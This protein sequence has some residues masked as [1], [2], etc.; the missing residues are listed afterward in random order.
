MSEKKQSNIYNFFINKKEKIS[1]SN[2]DVCTSLERELCSDSKSSDTL[3]RK[4]IESGGG[5][6]KKLKSLRKYN[7]DYLRFGFIQEPGSDFH[8]RPLCVVCSE[9]LSND[10]MKP[11]KLDRHLQS[12]HKD[13]AKKPLEYFERM[14]GDMQR[15]VISMKKMTTEDKSL[16]KASYLVALQIAKNKKAYTIGEDLIKPCMLQVCEEVL[17]NQAVKK[18]KEIP[19]SANTIKRRIEE[20]AEDIENQVIIMVK[21]SPFYSIQLDESTDVNNKALLLCF[22]RLEYEGNLLEELLCSLNLPGRTTSSEIFETL[23]SYFCEH[24]IEWK[25]CIGICTDGAANMV[26]RLSGV[27]AK[28]KKVGH[29]DILSTHCILHREQLASKKMSPE[30]N[31][32]LSD[33]INIVNLI[34]HKALNSRLF[35]AL[36]EE[37][38]SQYTH[39]LLHAEVRWLSRGKILSRLFA[40]REEVKLFFQQQNNLKF[41]ELLSDDEWVAKLAYLSDIFSLLNELNISMQGQLKDVFTLRDK[42]EA[43]KKKLLLWKTRLFEEDMQMFSN[44]DEYLKEKDN[45][46]H[47][48]IVVRHHLA[49]LIEAFD[50]YFPKNEDPRHGNMWIIDPFA[51]ANNENNNLSMNEKESLIDLSSDSS[52]KAK[53]QSTASKS[54]FWLYVKNEYPMLSEKAVK[55]LIQFSTTYL[56]EKTFSSVTTIKTRYRSRLDISTA[57]RL[58]VT[59]LEPKIQKLI[60]NKQEQ[61][62]H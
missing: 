55:L 50:R 26:G 41:Q 58:A 34:R 40:L 16:L 47:V 62:S 6:K 36:C 57:L 20:M 3:I 29:P 5:E 61:V 24:G 31:E 39:L 19:M 33:V 14:R 51:V 7:S 27:V 18:L 52:L 13:L 59:T 46:Q 53:F 44:F 48:V 54:Q 28:V 15:Q 23:N 25:K 56:C 4:N 9:I 60:Q 45:N 43:F 11:S 17:G 12:K 10:A 30:L 42:I 37:L 21:N 38:G 32:V 35:E 2:G 22:V 1:I 49:S 8:P